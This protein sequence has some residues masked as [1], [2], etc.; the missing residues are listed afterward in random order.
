MAR[1]ARDLVAP[2]GGTVTHTYSA[3]LDGFAVRLPAAAA[4]VLAAQP[5]VASVEPDVR[6]SADRTQRSATWGLDRSDQATRRLDGRYTYPGTAGRGAHVYVVDTGLS[7]HTEFSGRVGAGRNFVG[8]LLT[9]P[10]PARW[11]DCNG[12]GTH[13]ASTAVG[14]RW[15]I[16]KR[17]T[18]HAV[19]VLD[20]A[21][22]GST[23]DILAGLD[24]VA[25]THQSPAVVNLSL[26]ST[27]RIAALDAAVRG[28]VRR[29]VAVSV[30]AGNDDRDACTESPAGEPSVLTVG[31]TDRADTRAGFSNFGR[32]VD[33]F[34]PGVSITGAR[35]GSR[36]AGT[37]M[38]GT[39]MAAPHVA[40]ALA[41]LRAAHPRLSAAAAQ[42][43]LVAA[44]TR[45]RVGRARRG[46]PGPPAADRRRPA[47][48]P[49]LV[50]LPGAALH[51]ARHGRRRR[52][53][54]P[55]P[56]AD[57]RPRAR[58]RPAGPGTQ[59]RAALRR[60]RPGP[61]HAR[62]GRHRRP[63]QQHHAEDPGPL[64]G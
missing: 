46:L 11:G 42:R 39:S 32:C 22:T 19:R 21:G 37:A 52:R 29:G 18:V 58:V 26:S 14:T 50:V 30:A 38:S 20:C 48:L 63:A 59:G 53:R 17:A 28:L 54:P 16:A 6:L 34:A 51:P 24:H 10:D 61:G 55:L 56:L 27:G 44:T 35:A 23:S 9:G 60:P 64:S 47:A 8:G 57:H 41:L 13:V 62:G 25:R 7:G 1:L 15:G 45:G 12:H 4:A 43:R 5:G 36:T 49:L 33:L 31:A 3:A 40:G 2:L